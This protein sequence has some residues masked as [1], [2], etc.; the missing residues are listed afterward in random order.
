MG[1]GMTGGPG[2]GGGR[3]TQAATGGAGGGSG[4]ADGLLP[5]RPL[6]GAGTFAFGLEGPR[7]FFLNELR[8]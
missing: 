7:G 2:G 6:D 5:H 3:G 8:S 4:G 1:G